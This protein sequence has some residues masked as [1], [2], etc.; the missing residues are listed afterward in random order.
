[1]LGDTWGRARSR[2]TSVALTS[3][4]SDSRRRRTHPSRPCVVAVIR[5]VHPNWAYTGDIKCHNARSV[6]EHAG[7]R[8]AT[9]DEDA[10]AKLGGAAGR[11]H[12]QRRRAPCSK[13]RGYLTPCRAAPCR[14]RGRPKQQRRRRRERP[15]EAHAAAHLRIVP[16]DAPSKAD[17]PPEL[18]LVAFLCGFVHGLAHRVAHRVLGTGAAH[19]SARWWRRVLAARE[20][21]PQS[22]RKSG[23][24]GP[25]GAKHDKLEVPTRALRRAT[26]GLPSWLQGPARTP[27]EGQR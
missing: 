22:E 4:A 7:V 19:S 20:S 18:H 10:C 11:R 1:M 13:L 25:K 14:R 8:R 26:A 15:R 9:C 12:S 5:A 3:I 21:R 6:D 23:S 24:R 17:K 27:D 2:L 16:V